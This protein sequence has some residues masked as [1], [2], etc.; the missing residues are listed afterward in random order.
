MGRQ[1]D[2]QLWATPKAL[3][4]TDKTD[5]TICRA[6]ESWF[7]VGERTGLDAVVLRRG[8]KDADTLVEEG[9]ALLIAAAGAELLAAKSTTAAENSP[10][11]AAAELAVAR[12]AAAT[13]GAA[14]ARHAALPRNAAGTAA[15]GAAGCPGKARKSG[16]S[17]FEAVVKV[18]WPRRNR[19]RW[20][21]S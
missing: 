9:I 5:R 16:A 13:R 3:L 10:K 1:R 2:Y 6:A 21:W 14:L 18:K 15:G 19:R 7:N 20:R 8:P 12:A 4:A 17:V 11:E